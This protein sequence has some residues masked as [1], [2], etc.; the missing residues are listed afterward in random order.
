MVKVLAKG[1]SNNELAK[2]L[3]TININSSPVAELC[4]QKE[5]LLVPIFLLIF[6]VLFP[7]LLLA[8]IDHFLLRW[9]INRP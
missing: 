3:K 6:L 5:R 8:F 1:K 2:G 4:L 9:D 7:F